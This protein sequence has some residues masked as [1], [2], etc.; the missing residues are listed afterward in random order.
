[1]ART[2]TVAKTSQTEFL[3]RGLDALTQRW[4]GTAALIEAKGKTLEGCLG[5]IKSAAV[6]GVADPVT[7]SAAI[8]KYY[9]I[10]LDSREAAVAVNLALMGQTAPTV[11]TAPPASAEAPAKTTPANPDFDLDALLKG[12]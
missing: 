11:E 10:E 7:A 8:L 5:A 12:L 9:G 1:M 4:P 3:R 2:N 6:G